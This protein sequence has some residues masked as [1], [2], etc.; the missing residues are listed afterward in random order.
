MDGL[1]L[2][3]GYAVDS[4]F[5]KGCVQVN[6]KNEIIVDGLGMTSCKGVFAAGDVTSVPFKQVVIAAGD[7]AKAALQAYIYLTGGQDANKY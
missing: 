4:A 6:E 5:L 3:I 1:F 7:G 2:E